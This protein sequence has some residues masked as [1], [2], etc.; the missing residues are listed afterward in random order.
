MYIS[1]DGITKQ[2]AGLPPEKP[3]SLCIAHQTNGKCA[4]YRSKSGFSPLTPG[5]GENVRKQQV[6]PAFRLF[7]DTSQ[8]KPPD[9]TSS[10][11]SDDRWHEQ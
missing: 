2:K 11:G 6:N 3:E 5:P 1:R 9:M 8:R 4:T 10:F 7:F